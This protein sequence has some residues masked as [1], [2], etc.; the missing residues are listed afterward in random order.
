MMDG[1]E[2]KGLIYDNVSGAR[3]IAERGLGMLQRAATT[4]SANEPAALLDELADLGVKLIRSKPEMPQVFQALNRFLLAAEAR[5]AEGGELGPFRLS[6]VSLL[7]EQVH[8]LRASLDRIA[9]HAEPLV[10]NGAVIVTHSR[11]ST[12][13]AALRRA[14]RAG[15]LFDVVVPESRPNLEG[16]TLAR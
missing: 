2:L 4:S 13:L 12:V 16:R 14:K 10:T 9:E 5:E 7:Q 3:E 1:G 11:S 15:R 8:A 6:L